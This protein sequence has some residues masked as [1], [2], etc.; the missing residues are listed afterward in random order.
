MQVGTRPCF[1]KCE[2]HQRT[3]DLSYVIRIPAPAMSDSGRQSLQIEIRGRHWGRKEYQEGHCDL[4]LL[5]G[6]EGDNIEAICQCRPRSRPQARL[7]RDCSARAMLLEVYSTRG[8]D[9]IGSLIK[10]ESWWGH[11]HYQVPVPT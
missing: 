4:I 8:E 2:Y 1:P 11:G 7:R 5:P 3:L 10:T 6:S 9:L